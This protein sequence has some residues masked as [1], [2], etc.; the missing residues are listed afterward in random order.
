[1]PRS[2][3]SR[4]APTNHWLTPSSPGCLNTCA[5]H[6]GLRTPAP[7]PADAASRRCVHG[8]Q[9]TP[10][11]TRGRPRKVSASASG[12]R[13]RLGQRRHVPRPAHD[14][15]ALVPIG[16][17]TS[18]APGAC[19]LHVAPRAASQPHARRGPRSSPRRR[20]RTPVGRRH[21]ARSRRPTT[22]PGR[23]AGGCSQRGQ[24][25][26]DGCRRVRADAIATR[27]R[28]R[29]A[30]ECCSGRSIARTGTPR[31]VGPS[32]RLPLRAELGERQ[33][34]GA[35]RTID[36]IA[37]QRHRRNEV[38]VAH[39]PQCLLA[40]GRQARRARPSAATRRGRAR[41]IGRNRDRDGGSPA[42]RTVGGMRPTARRQAS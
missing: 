12:R 15:D 22:A 19:E 24:R 5:Y 17:R 21:D 33:E 7:Y 18:Q 2:R 30:N 37:E 32:E 11:F 42:A 16:D 13:Q 34:G 26:A 31:V 3:S 39:P 41:P 1:M 20:T 29:P 38:L 27:R 40:V 36:H 25:I 35:L 6:P 8:T 4:A 10:T 9:H 14:R 28:H 23:V